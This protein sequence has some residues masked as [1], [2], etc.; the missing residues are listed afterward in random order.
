VTWHDGRAFTADD[1]AF[2]LSRLPKVSSGPGTCR[3]GDR[4]EFT[5]TASCWAGAQPWARVSDRVV[6]NDAARSAALLAGDVDVIDQ[7]PSSDLA[8]LGRDQRVSLHEIQGLRPPGLMPNVN[9]IEDALSSPTMMAGRCRADRSTTRGC[10]VRCRW[11]STAQREVLLREAVRIVTVD[12]APV[13]PLD[14]LAKFGATRRAFADE[15]RMDERT[16]AMSVTPARRR[17][18]RPG[19]RASVRRFPPGSTRRRRGGRPS[20][21]RRTAG[22][23]G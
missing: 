15:A 10:G 13:I 12:D 11:R 20:P 8:R 7:G 16:T 14:Q 3:C 18:L 1:V 19:S 17:A 23:R 5:R 9:R 22:C 6:A 2:T 4:T 21:P